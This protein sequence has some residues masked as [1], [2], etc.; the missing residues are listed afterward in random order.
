MA[1]KKKPTSTCDQIM[2]GFCVFSGFLALVCI[3]PKVPYRYA[4][5]Y[6][7][8][9]QRYALQR[10]YS[11]WGATDHLGAIKSWMSMRSDACRKMIEISTQ[12]PLMSAFGTVGASKVGTGG[13]VVGCQFWQM[14]KEDIVQRCNQYTMVMA[15]GMT[16]IV[17]NLIGAVALFMVPMMVNAEKEFTGK[18][19][20]KKKKFVEAVT[21]TLQTVA[22]GFVFPMLSYAM[23]MLTTDAMFHALA[24]RAA[25]PYGYA[26]AGAFM[27][28]AVVF[29]TL[30]AVLIAGRRWSQAGEEKG[31]DDEEGSEDESGM[32]PAGT[33]Q[34]FVDPASLM[35]PPGMAPPGMGPPG[36]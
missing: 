15:I 24:Q 18:S 16:S 14:C 36:I 11:L 25:Y 17:F 1:K 9:H 10:E 29:F 35:A 19:K 28:G 33:Q 22:A 2:I 4:Q 23:Y 13:A 32:A 5:M 34:E 21:L 30:V 31:S 8:F 3:I 6:S 7:G 12:N 27:S 26:Y 20:K